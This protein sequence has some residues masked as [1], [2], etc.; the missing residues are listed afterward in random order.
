MPSET[1]LETPTDWL[2]AAASANRAFI[3]TQAEWSRAGA[4]HGTDLDRLRLALRDARDAMRD[5]RDA[6]YSYTQGGELLP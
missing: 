2:S 5:A 6:A 4:Q 3:R 1:R